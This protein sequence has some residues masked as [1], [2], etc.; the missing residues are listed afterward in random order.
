MTAKRTEEG[1]FWEWRVFGELPDS[2]LD[3]VRQFEERGIGNGTGEDFYFVSEL[4]DQNVKLRGDDVLKLKPLLVRLEDGVEL[5]EETSRLT[6]EL[7][8]PAEAVEK[9]GHLL[10]VALEPSAAM[11]SFAVRSAFARVS[12]VRFVPVKKQRTQYTVGDG[13]VE[14]AELEFPSATVRSLGVQ[15]PSLAE[16][17]RLR[18][19]LDP[20]RALRPLNYVE[21]CRRW[22]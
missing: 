5:Y 8:A 6:Y 10:G 20:A 2:L 3:R 16:T 21:A 15:S 4:T 13:W 11:D 12:S 18:D 9:A 22:G 14:V 17:R 19:L 7:P 1:W